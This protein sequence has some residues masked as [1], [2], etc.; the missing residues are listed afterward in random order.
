MHPTPLVETTRGYPD[1]GYTAENV[2]RGS[3]AV[4]DRDGTL[5][6]QAG[7]P[8]AL[9]FTRSALKPFQ[10]LPLLRAGGAERFGLST[11]ELA[12]L[13]ASHSGEPMHV[14]TVRALLSKVDMAEGELACGCHAPLYYDA[15]GKAAPQDVR[16]SAVHHNCSGK[17]GGFLAWPTVHRPCSMRAAARWGRSAPSS[18]SRARASARVA[19]SNDLLKTI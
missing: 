15:V 5:L 14:Q 18:R 13:C 12:M 4:V 17:H 16:W 11:A 8:H 7:D 3:V 1:S 9:T 10:A 19:P 2:H 6:W